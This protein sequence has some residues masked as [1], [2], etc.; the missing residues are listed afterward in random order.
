VK[1]DNAKISDKIFG[2]DLFACLLSPLGVMRHVEVMLSRS[3]SGY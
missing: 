3:L 1:I 2:Y